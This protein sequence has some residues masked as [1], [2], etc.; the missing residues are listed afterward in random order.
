VIKDQINLLSE[1]WHIDPESKVELNDDHMVKTKINTN[2]SHPIY[3]IYVV[4]L[5]H[6][7]NILIYRL[8]KHI[9]IFNYMVSLI[10]QLIHFT[11]M[12]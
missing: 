8:I 5:S 10:Q 11:T 12:T 1:F 6:Q 3:G 9:I 2:G 7:V 4:L